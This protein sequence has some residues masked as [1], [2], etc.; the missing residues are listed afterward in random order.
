[1]H[2]HF[3]IKKT[4]IAL[5]FCLLLCVT[6]TLA[7]PAGTW[8]LY[9][10]YT[11]ISKV[12]P[13]GNYIF[14]LCDG[15]LFSYNQNDHSVAEHNKLTGLTSQNI[16]DIAA[17]KTAKKLL[18]IYEDYTID[19]LPIDLGKEI[20]TIV[21]L[22]EKL[23]AK[24]K[25]ITDTRIN[26]KYAYLTTQ[27]LGTLK[28]NT[29]NSTIEETYTHDEVIPDDERTAMTVDEYKT[30]SNDAKPDGPETNRFWKIYLHDGK[31]FCPAGYYHY[32]MAADPN[33]PIL[34]RY[35]DLSNQTWTTLPAPNNTELGY[36][37]VDAN[38]MAF[39]PNDATH[40]WIGSRSGLLEY[41]NYSYYTIYNCDNSTLKS[42]GHL[43][44]NSRVL[45]SSM[46]YDNS[47]NL[48]VMN[49]R[50]NTP[51][52]CYSSNSSTPWR[53]FPH[54]N[55]DFTGRNSIDMQEAFISTTNGLMWWVNTFGEPETTSSGIFVYDYNNDILHKYG[56]FT[57]QNSENIEAAKVYAVSEDR[58]GNMWIAS[59]S[60]PFYIDK[61]EIPSPQNFDSTPIFHQPVINRNDGSNL[62]DYLLSSV[63]LRCIRT[64]FAN[65]KWMGSTTSG[66]F[67]ISAD[68]QTEIEH[69]TTE[70]SPLPSDEIYDIKID[71]NTGIVYISTS[72]GLCS[73]QSDITS[74]YGTLEEDNIYA[75]PN[76]VSPDYTGPI[77]IK[78]LYDQ[79]QIKI[80][81]SSGYIVHK[82]VVSG[83]TYTW[84][85]CDFNGDRVASG[86]YMVLIETPE[87]SK[88]CVTKIAMIK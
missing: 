19:L 43:N 29:L 14:A 32:E 1:M 67:L 78:G 47:G 49:S 16:I 6:P 61:D 37:A 44:N 46:T 40:F 58:T 73:Y 12:E 53:T 88:G 20:T 36:E 54:T 45:I 7:E 85:G 18:I 82:G 22:K 62:G 8:R 69:F 21:G 39:D 66:V 28:I 38:C 3:M 51:I 25:T 4:L 11:N 5:Q 65:R 59:L 71:D 30:L 23:T 70:N 80:T 31:L 50:T 76:P 15:N 72:R 2:T 9:N 41:R 55:L 42:T 87:G 64:D 81:T 86:V 17:C 34:T 84:D 13:I 35:Y 56:T 77:T 60:G 57:N 52:N 33:Y 27:G 24:D 79:C 83:G 74:E 26:G 48:W 68:N 75:Y 63:P 10:S